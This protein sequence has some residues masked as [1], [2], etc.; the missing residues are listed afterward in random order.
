MSFLSVPLPL[1]R[2]RLEHPVL[3]SLVIGTTVPSLSLN[4][5]TNPALQWDNWARAIGLP[6]AC[7]AA[8]G[9]ADLSVAIPL[10]NTGP[11]S[12]AFPCASAIAFGAAAG[13]A[14]AFHTDTYCSL[15]LADHKVEATY[16]FLHIKGDIGSF[17]GGAPN[18]QTAASAA[19][20]S[21]PISQAVN[22]HRS[23]LDGRLTLSRSAPAP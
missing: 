20:P 21:R 15:E 4:P 9:P 23:S 6:A 3:K 1:L 13:A 10:V 5:T 2:H 19:R 18:S 16:L 11:S 12:L 7:P 14:I 8:S 17:A 22:V